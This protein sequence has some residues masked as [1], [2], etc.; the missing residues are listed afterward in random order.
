MKAL[1]KKVVAMAVA[2]AAGMVAHAASIVYAA[3]NNVGT[4]ANTPYGIVLSVTTP[5]SGCTVEYA[6]A[7]DGPWQSEPI[8]FTDACTAQTVWYKISASGYDT[9]TGSNTVTVNPK[10]LDDS[11]VWVTLPTA[12]Y[13]YD[14]TEKKPAPAAD[15]PAALITA[16]DYDVTYEDNI[17]AGTAKAIFTGKRNYTGTV[18]VEFDIEKAQNSWTTAP[19]LAGW[20]YGQTPSTP[21]S[22]ALNGTAVVTY[23]AADGTPLAEQP[24]MPGTYT[25]VFTVAESANYKALSTDVTFTISGAEIECQTDPASYGYDGNGHG[26]V[27]SV[28]KPANGYTVE[29]SLMDGGPWQTTPFLFTNV[30]AKTVYY[31]VT[32]LGYNEKTGT[33]NVTISA[34]TLDDTFVWV[35]LPTAGYVYDGTAKTPGASIGDGTSAPITVDDFTVAYADNVNAGTAT[36]TFTG[37]GNFTGSFEETFEIAKRQITLTSGDGTWEQ[38]GAAHSNVTVTVGGDG[39]VAGE[40]ATYSGFPEVSEEGT[41]QNTFTVTFNNGTLASNYDVTSVYGTL[42][43][44]APAVT[45]YEET[46]EE[47]IYKWEATGATTAKIVGFKNASQ[48]VTAMVLPDKIEGYFITEIA[49]GAFANSKCGAT[50]VKLP[51]CCT[52]IGFRA[53]SGIK[54]LAHVTFV[55]VLDYANLGSAATLE[56]GEYAFA[57]TALTSVTTPSCVS[58]IGDYAFADCRK[59]TSVTCAG[60]PT[61]GTRPFRRAGVDMGITEDLTVTTSGMQ[62]TGKAVRM[63][64]SVAA[65]VP[66]GAI[67]AN[68][69]TVSYRPTLDATPT[70]LTPTVVERAADGSVTVEVTPP[71]GASSGFFQATLNTED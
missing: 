12:G 36:A 61:L 15:D 29:Y 44:T 59:L 9:V 37:R 8:T 30:C 66:Y 55:D 5:T 21:T 49:R 4:Y 3:D 43:I 35:T 47:T 71:E 13:A 60:S 1:M 41:S 48:K 65:S 38:D 69:L 50:S 39:F 11:L 32:A 7:E 46:D 26:I 67:D 18:E 57:A 64:L 20:T 56:I 62:V 52:K 54:T 27:L 25:A 17:D 45:L 68:A 34:R 33:A 40:G 53:F 6:T 63:T 16:D 24:T 19:S 42:T 2:G 70:T 14:G 23:K 10:T 28:T 31:R 22:V 58:K 51:R